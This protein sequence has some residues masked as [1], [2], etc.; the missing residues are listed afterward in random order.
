MLEHEDTSRFWASVRTGTELPTP[1]INTNDVFN[2]CFPF[3]TY[4]CVWWDEAMHTAGSCEGIV[5]E[6]L[7]QSRLHPSTTH[8]YFFFFFRK[9]A[10]SRMSLWTHQGKGPG[11]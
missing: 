5:K 3:V 8:Y 10:L 4:T 2:L 11:L 9:A 1:N 6:F 7:L